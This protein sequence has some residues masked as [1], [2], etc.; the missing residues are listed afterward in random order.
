MKNFLITLCLLLS[1]VGMFAQK[2]IDNEFFT[3]QVPKNWE[4]VEMPLYDDTIGI[5]QCVILLDAKDKNN[6]NAGIISAYEKQLD[7]NTFLGEDEI[8]SR[9]QSYGNNTTIKLG[10][11]YSTSFYSQEAKAKKFTAMSKDGSITVSGVAYAVYVNSYSVL[12]MELS[13]PNMKTDFG[14]LWQTIQWKEYVKKAEDTDAFKKELETTINLFNAMIG[15]Q[16]AINGMKIEGF[17]LDTTSK[18]ILF[19]LHYIGVSKNDFSA[20][21]LNGMKE[22]FVQ[23][24]GPELIEGFM[25]NLDILN[26]ALEKGYIYKIEALDKNGETL[27]NDVIQLKKVADENNIQAN[28]QDDNGPGVTVIKQQTNEQDYKGPIFTVVEQMPMFTGGD[29][30]LMNYL[31]H[32]IH[33]PEVA[34]KNGVQGR[35]VVGF[36]VECDGSITNVNILRG[37]DPSLD[38]EAMRVVRAM[39]KWIPGK[40]D[41]S[42]VRVKYQVPISFSL[43]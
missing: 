13:T 20:K 15:E 26:E 1:S 30:E 16:P 12:I 2:T 9:M 38:R 21:D 6:G 35:V 18:S 40:K 31:A 11:I 8:K 23:E 28:E 39:P 3:M 29:A 42:V 22:A 14:K 7:L 5:M 24:A 34:A 33:Y 36:V 32:N 4:C 41:G 19:K 37:V 17:D 10:D 27:V 43:R 25:E